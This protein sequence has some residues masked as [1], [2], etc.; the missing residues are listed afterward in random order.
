MA[1]YPLSFCLQNNEEHDEILGLNYIIIQ[2]NTSN[3]NFINEDSSILD[4]ILGFST[5][6]MN[7]ITNNIKT[8]NITYEI[9]YNLLETPLS[10]HYIKNSI[11]SKEMRKDFIEK[12]YQKAQE[13]LAILHRGQD[14]SNKLG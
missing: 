7:F 9:V 4:Y 3:I 1:N 6:A 11:Y 5:N 10:L 8:K 14:L 12:G 13:F 2:N